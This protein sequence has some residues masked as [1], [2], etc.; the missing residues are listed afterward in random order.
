VPIVAVKSLRIAV[1]IFSSLEAFLNGRGFTQAAKCETVSVSRV[2]RCGISVRNSSQY[3]H[4]HES[5]R[6]K[7]MKSVPGGEEDIERDRDCADGAATI[8][9]KIIEFDPNHM[10]RWHWFDESP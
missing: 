9:R 4:L 2:N 8:K 7:L 5:A 6:L 1:A 3:R 10:I